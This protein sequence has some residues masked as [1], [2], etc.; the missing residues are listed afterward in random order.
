MITTKKGEEFDA[1][2]WR[3]PRGSLIIEQPVPG[4]MLFTYHGHIPV[5]VVPLIEAS[6][7]RVLNTGIRP[8]LFID[9][10]QMKGYDSEYRKAISKWGADNHRRL[11]DV[12][13]LVRSKLIA[14]R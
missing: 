10:E 13:V 11:G 2:T 1:L 9:L 8:D 6:V 14:M 5:E 7:A 3:S 4:V 12:R